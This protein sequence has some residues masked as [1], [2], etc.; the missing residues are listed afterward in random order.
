V[1]KEKFEMKIKI[2]S[3]MVSSEKARQKYADKLAAK[4]KPNDDIE[5]RV[6]EFIAGKKVVAIKPAVSGEFGSA[7]L[8]ITVLYEA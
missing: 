1:A 3:D 6:N 8:V 7:Q 5:C 4:K 2:F